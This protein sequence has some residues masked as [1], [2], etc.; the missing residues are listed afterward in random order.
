MSFMRDFRVGMK[1]KLQATVLGR[2]LLY[3]VL[4]VNVQPGAYVL[5]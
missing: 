2:D 3:I 5:E 4:T 1:P